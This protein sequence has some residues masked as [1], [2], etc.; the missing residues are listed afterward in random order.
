MFGLPL[1]AGTS[2]AA[3]P[4]ES[5][6]ALR[7]LKVGGPL[8]HPA[9][10]DHLDF[11]REL[12]FN[13]VWL[14]GRRAGAWDALAAPRGPMLDPAFLQ[15]A[16]TCRERGVRLFVDV[17]PVLGSERPFVFSRAD[18]RKRLLRFVR[19]LRRD[20]GVTDVSL[21]FTGV[22]P[23]LHELADL[24]AFGL[25]ASE[26]HSDLVNWLAR[27][28]PGG[29]RLWFSPT[30]WG[31]DA[32]T[33]SIAA[34]AKSLGEKVADF[35]AGV[36][37]VWTGPGNP[38]TAIR[39]A[40]VE[41]ARRGV[42][43]RPLILEDRF[44]FNG[45]GTR[46]SLALVL[47]PLREREPAIA[48]GLAGYLACPMTQLGG[49]RLSLMTVADFLASP[50]TYDADRSWKKAQQRLAG[51]SSAARVAL[52][53][54][55]IEWGGWIGE[56]NYH[57]TRSDH[58]RA[59][60]A[61]LRDPAYVA[62]WTWTVRRYP[63]RMQALQSM[64]DRRFREDLLE[65]MGRRL[66]IA[67]AM[68]VVQELRA[69]RRAGRTDIEALLGQIRRERQRVETTPTIRLA[70]DRFLEAAGILELLSDPGGGTDSDQR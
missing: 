15:F 51:E 18:D 32:T 57:T 29:T 67:R 69:R 65:I 42:G 52:D 60:A 25:V 24:L 50:E 68:P 3:D 40:D 7:I 43:G 4:T 27:R 46:L 54:Q 55:T 13:A 28:V 26:A 17:H 62:S 38:A 56:R 21:S 36:G 53:T 1:L 44:P 63:E 2:Q 61:R 5:P 9:V 58:P 16:E 20:A 64:H 10:R 47:A 8:E 6:F 59:A 14:A 49:S 37:L 31:Y 48:A 45:E 66:A 34:Y 33:P 35:P 11:G 23:R 70:L 19:L 41:E 39:A 12:G 30:T 22:S